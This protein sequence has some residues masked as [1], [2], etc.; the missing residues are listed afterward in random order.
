MGHGVRRRQKRVR[1]VTPN[2]GTPRS[3]V[4][5]GSSRWWLP[6]VTFA[7]KP[8]QLKRE[9]RICDVYSRPWV[10]SP[11]FRACLDRL[12]ELK[13]QRRPTTTS[14]GAN[15]PGGRPTSARTSAPK[16]GGTPLNGPGSPGRMASR[17]GP[18]PPPVRSWSISRARRA[19]GGPATLRAFYRFRRTATT[20]P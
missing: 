5:S 7:G 12:R 20:S 8:N 4:R 1:I 9:V 10:S 6:D 2:R 13:L 15:A 19:P 17:R 18:N 3:R 11:V 14:I 16:F